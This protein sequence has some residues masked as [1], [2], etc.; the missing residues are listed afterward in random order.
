MKKLLVLLSMAA[1]VA[2]TVAGLSGAFGTAT[3]PAVYA[4]RLAG[5]Y[6]NGETGIQVQNL[7]A[8]QDAQITAS[9]YPQGGGNPTDVSAPA[10]SACRMDCPSGCVKSSA[11]DCL[12]RFTPR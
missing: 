1:V 8:S 7:D 4:S 12:L 11:T 2:V 9:F 6:G 5:I 3:P 10:T